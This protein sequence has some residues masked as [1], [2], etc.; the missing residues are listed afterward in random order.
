MDWVYFH[1]VINHFPIVGVIIG[2]LLLAVGMI[3]KNRGV[4]ISGLGTIVFA[5]L[6]AIV[7]YMSGD[8]A[9]DVVRGFPDVLKSLVSRHENIATIGMY[10][11]VPAGLM[12]ASSL[13]SIWKKD[14]AVHFFIIIT[15]VFSLISSGTMVYIG[16]TGGQ[17]RHT[18][19]RNEATKQY[20]IEHQNDTEGE[21]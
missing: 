9:A 3:F 10:L 14:K 15:L 8:P 13:Y 12:A 5:A 2:T 4:E 6:T 11:M 21:Y 17:I 7:A 18:E 16:R 19:F 20:I 1:V